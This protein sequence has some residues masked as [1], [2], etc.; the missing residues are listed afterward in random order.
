VCADSTA[1]SGVLSG[2][3]EVIHGALAEFELHVD[4]IRAFHNTTVETG[5]GVPFYL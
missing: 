3:L 2:G 1:T 4:L 5:L